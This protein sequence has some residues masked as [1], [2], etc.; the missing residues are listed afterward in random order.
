LQPDQR[1][2]VPDPLLD[3]RTRNPRPFHFKRIGDIV[4]H[5]EMRPD[6]IGLKHH[7]DRALVHGDEAVLI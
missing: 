3:L 2:Y 7:S 6:R 1:E 4:E 5:V